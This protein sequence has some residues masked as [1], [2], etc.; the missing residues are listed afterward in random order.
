MDVLF[1]SPSP[2]I[3]PATWSALFVFAHAGPPETPLVHKEVCQKKMG[4]P[5]G[6]ATLAASPR[7]TVL[8]HSVVLSYT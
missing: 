5:L 2:H 4:I 1:S 3:L 6:T 7:G 8:R